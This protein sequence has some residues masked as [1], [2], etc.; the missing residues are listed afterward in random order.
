MTHKPPYQRIRILKSSG[1]V[2]NVLRP[3]DWIREAMA[4]LVNKSVDGVSVD[5]LAKNLGLTRGSFYHHFLDRDDLL[6]RVLSTWRQIQTDQVINRYEQSNLSPLGRIHELID[7]PF[8]GES[9]R[10]GGSV[11]LAIRAWARRDALARS[12][13][14]EVD[15]VRMNYIRHC[16]ELLGY[17]KES[18]RHVAFLL[19]GYM[20]AESIFGLPGDE[21]EREARRKYVIDV[22]FKK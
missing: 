18:Q 8:R 10:M 3:E 6:K 15:V 7:L 13:V 1:N 14:D 12:V 21:T 4:V 16:F 19:Y 22:L 20:Q 17:K 11:E 5:T 9:A 2:K